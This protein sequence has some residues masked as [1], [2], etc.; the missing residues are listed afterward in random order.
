MGKE[1]DTV[2]EN[3]E[4]EHEVEDEDGNGEE[5]NGSVHKSVCVDDSIIES[6]ET[7]DKN[8]EEEPRENYDK[9]YHK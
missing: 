9:L 3:E 4:T 7:V 5:D 6:V 1:N 2:Q 8:E